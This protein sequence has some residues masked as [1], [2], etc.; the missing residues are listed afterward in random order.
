[1]KP[2]PKILKV[3]I[4]LLFVIGI[5]LFYVVP[6]NKYEWMQEIDPSITAA[7]IESTSGNGALFTF[8]M[9]ILIVLT[10]IIF[11]AKSTRM[12]EKIV[13]MILIVIAVVFWTYKF[14]L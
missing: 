7:S 14:W 11:F 9:L 4:H 3:I 2:M 5:F 6:V 8:L 13:S 1:M 10:Q 12:T